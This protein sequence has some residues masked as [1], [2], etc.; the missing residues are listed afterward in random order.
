[1]ISVRELTQDDVEVVDRHLPLNRLDQ[2]RRERSTFL[3]AWLEGRPVG[4]AHIA[5]TGT[6]L[7]VPEIQDVFVAEDVRRRGIAGALTGAAE[8]QV[9]A[10]GH[11][12]VSLS[13][14]TGNFAARTLYEG[15]GFVDAGLEPEPTS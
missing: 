4:H 6:R 8:T 10:R 2:W 9:L 5:W 15:L 13:V 7:D 11:D 12:R 1:M 3:V 14:G